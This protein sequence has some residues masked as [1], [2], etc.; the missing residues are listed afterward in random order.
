MRIRSRSCLTRKTDGSV[1][2]LAL[3]PHE[4]VLL[5]IKHLKVMDGRTTTAPSKKKIL[6]TSLLRSEKVPLIK[7]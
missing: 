7:D 4:L 5:G 3:L 6:T 1:P 2:A